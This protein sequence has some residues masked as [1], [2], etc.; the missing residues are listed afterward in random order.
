M[1]KMY[2]TIIIGSGSAGLS[3]AV[4]AKRAVLDFIVIEK[5]YLGTG[6]IAESGRV[7]NYLGLYGENGFDLGEKFREHAAA[8]G[9][10]FLEGEVISIA[11][12]GN[13]YKIVL[14]DN[15][16]L[17]TKSIIFAT[18]AA[19]RKLDIQGESEF[20]GRGV[21]YCAVCDGAFYK[22]KITAVVGG[23]DTALEDALLLSR[24]CKKVYLVHRRDE[25]RANK[26]LQNLVKNTENIELVLNAK[27]CEI[28]GD[29]KVN[30]LKILQNGE[31]RTLELDGVF[32]AVGTVPNSKLLNGIAELDSHGYVVADETGVTSA[33]GIFAAGDV[34]TKQLRQVSTAVADGANSVCSLE[35]FLGCL[36]G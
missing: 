11:K 5:E 31:E 7:D 22:D 35:R 30:A 2:D 33:Q 14:S 26:S 12:D 32:A 1:N 15:S 25:F 10:E 28:I 3:A 24:T 4:Y 36:K 23:G 34:R 6:Q 9:T 20:S 16:E 13:A 18:G 29:K 21:S 8:L 17:L 19:P 27:P